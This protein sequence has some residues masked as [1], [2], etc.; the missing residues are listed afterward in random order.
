MTAK[1][2][3]LEAIESAGPGCFTAHVRIMGVSYHF[4]Y[5]GPIKADEIVA[6]LAH[7]GYDVSAY[8]TQS[9]PL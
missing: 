4:G 7:D 2:T 9:Q 8:L 3:I 6:E 5:E 1:K